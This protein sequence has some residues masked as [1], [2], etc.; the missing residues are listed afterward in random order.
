[1]PSE[2]RS[3]TCVPGRSLIRGHM[4]DEFL[5]GLDVEKRTNM[6]R[7]LTQHPDKIIFVAEH[8][9]NNIEGFSA[10]GPSRDADANAEHR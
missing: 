2:L 6:W 7:E 9:E 1:M 8:S 10:L 5:D 3:S 4:P